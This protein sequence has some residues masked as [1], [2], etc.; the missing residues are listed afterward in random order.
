ME[1]IQTA[2]GVICRSTHMTAFSAII[3]PLPFPFP[4]NDYRPI[5]PTQEKILK[6]LSSIGSG[7]SIIGLAGTI[8]TY[9][10]FRFNVQSTHNTLTLPT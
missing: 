7:L 2:D 1:T 3:D 9:G 6:I 5:S 4:G 8:L 10:L